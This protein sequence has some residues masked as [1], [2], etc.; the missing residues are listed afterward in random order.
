MS[1]E[2][3]QVG[4]TI[5]SQAPLGARDTTYRALFQADGTPAALVR[6][7][8]VSFPNPVLWKNLTV[9]ERSA[10]IEDPT[11]KL[12][13]A[14]RNFKRASDAAQVTHLTLSPDDF[15]HANVG[16]G[17]VST[18]GTLVHRPDAMGKDMRVS[19]ALRDVANAAKVVLDYADRGLFKRI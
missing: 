14:L 18:I 17:I 11:G 4:F 10:Q 8:D 6:H 1:G 13:T 3:T 5:G 16:G 9:Y 19:A 7:T 2:L 15:V 12:D